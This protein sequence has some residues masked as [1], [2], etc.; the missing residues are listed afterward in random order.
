M[1]TALLFAAPRAALA[2]PTCTLTSSPVTIYP[3]QGVTLT[4]S[5]TG[6]TSATIDNGIGS[7]AVNGSKSA[8]SLADSTTYTATV[9]GADG[10]ATCTTRVMVSY[11]SAT[12]LGGSGGGGGGSSAQTMQGLGQLLGGAGQLLNALGG[13]NAVNERCLPKVQLDGCGC[14]RTMGRK[15]CQPD[16]SNRQ[17]CPCSNTTNGFVTSGQCMASGKCLGQVSGGG[18][19]ALGGPQSGLAGGLQALGSILQGLSS[20]TGG[21][22][23]GG[24]G[25][26]PGGSAFPEGCSSYYYTSSPT[27]TD[28]CAIYMPDSSGTTIETGL[29]G[30]LLGALGG[31]SGTNISEILGTGG[32]T[33]NQGN[34]VSS[35]NSSSSTSTNR[36]SLTGDAAGSTVFANLKR[37]LSEVAGFFGGETLSKICK[38]RPWAGGGFLAGAAPDSFFDDLCRKAGYL[39]NQFSSGGNNSFT[40][41]GDT[42]TATTTPV[43]RSGEAQADIRAEPASVRLG[44]R[45]YVFW[46]SENVDSCVVS[47]PSFTETSLFGAGATVPITGPTTFT[48]NCSN[49]ST[50]VSDSVTVNLAI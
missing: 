38:S 9:T 20:L 39:D 14:G 5:S 46:T 26:Y 37:G 1:V 3:G 32:N 22:G 17:L 19:G 49:A 8:I 11:E 36:D 27:S 35:S 45:T 33:N 50:T 40:S 21:G 41:N 6:A 29:S 31:S 4:L 34:N 47:G 7:I 12:G 42:Q 28:R 23:G 30:S 48:I 15:G 43:G 24:G 44:T 16:P 10:S 25:A 2:A 18:S 13:S